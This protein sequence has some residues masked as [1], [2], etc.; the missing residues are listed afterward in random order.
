MTSSSSGRDGAAEVSP[1]A[2]F[3]HG[4]HGTTAVH[5]VPDQEFD[6]VL[7]SLLLDVREAFLADFRSVFRQFGV[8]DQQFRVLNIL[9]LSGDLEIGKLARRGR[10]VAPSMTGILNRMVEI[11][12]VVRKASKGQRWGRVSLTTEG[13][14]LIK[15]LMPPVEERLAAIEAALGPQHLEMLAGLLVKARTVLR[16][17]VVERPETASTDKHRVPS[18]RSI[19]RK[20]RTQRKLSSPRPK[21]RR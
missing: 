10:I 18:R 2:V 7:P 5:P 1:L 16:G 9:Y 17:L 8:T 12:W 11:G 21:N 15:R 13:R 4:A 6:D 20:R 14:R 3:T 19:S